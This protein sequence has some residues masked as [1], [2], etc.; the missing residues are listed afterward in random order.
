MLSERVQQ[1]SQR[2][3]EPWMFAPMGSTLYDKEKNPSGTVSFGTAENV[4]TLHDLCPLIRVKS[5]K[6]DRLPL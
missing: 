3:S 4:C 6:T 5:C 1:L 2:L